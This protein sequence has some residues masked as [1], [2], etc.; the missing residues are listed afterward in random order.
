MNEVLDWLGSHGKAF[1]SINNITASIGLVLATIWAV[2][3]FIINRAFI[4]HLEFTVNIEFITQHNDA[5]IIEVCST[6]ENK[7][8][9]NATLYHLGF[10]LRTL[11]ENDALREGGS[12]INH[13][14]MIPN[15]IKEG[16]WLP[17]DWVYTFIEPGTMQRY[18]YVY[19]V[20][21]SAKIILVHG[22]CQ[23]QLSFR[24]WH[25]YYYTSDK[26]IALPHQ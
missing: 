25:T 6:I 10:D 11:C 23:F 2:H 7:G 8:A 16:S 21:S 22:K 18:S 1:S 13:Q 19:H 4:P 12:Q 24:P 20:E 15:K 9:V 17:A 26:I 14:T 5:W 3:R